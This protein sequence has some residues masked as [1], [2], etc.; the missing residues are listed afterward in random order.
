MNFLKFFYILVEWKSCSRA[1]GKFFKIIMKIPKWMAKKTFY[2]P[3]LLVIVVAF[4]AHQA[5]E[6]S[7]NLPENDVNETM[8]KIIKS[9]LSDVVEIPVEVSGTILPKEYTR[10]QSKVGAQVRYMAPVGSSVTRG[11]PVVEFYDD[12]I[13]QTYFQSLVAVN[14]AQQNL[15]EVLGLT[16]E[17]IRQAELAVDSAMASLKSA[18]SS[19][20][21]VQ[22]QNSQNLSA[23]LDSAEVA[24]ESAYNTID[25]VLRYWGKGGSLNEFIL[26]DTPNSN[27]SLLNDTTNKFESLKDEYM[28]LSPNISGD[29]KLALVSI[30][31]VLNDTRDFN[32]SVFK[33][34]NYSVAIPALDYPQS[35]IDTYKLKSIALSSQINADNTRVKT[36]K[37]SVES[38]DIASQGAYIS[39]KNQYDQAQIMYDN[40]LIALDSTRRQSDIRILGAQ[41]Q[42][43]SAQLQ[44]TRA[45]E[46]YDNLYLRAPFDGVIIS[47]Q[48]NVGDQVSPGYQIIEMGKTDSVE[49]KLSID[50][51]GAKSLFIGKEVLINDKYV[52]SISEISPTASLTTGKMTFTVSA[53]NTE[54]SLTPGSV[55][56]V[57]ITTFVPLN[58]PAVVLNL[59]IVT[60]NQNEA[61]V[62]IAKPSN[63]EWYE[64]EKREVSLGE[65][66]NNKVIVT[67]GIDEG[68]LII[69]RSGAFISEG[70]RVMTLKE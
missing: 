60:V 6:P 22:L 7:E 65:T 35:L 57:S 18:K 41:S 47:Q 56:R 66:Y 33:V 38:V 26:R 61:F 44:L 16:A 64:V 2:L 67:Q 8:V 24:Y 45:R 39:A 11:E 21:N 36:S 4:V 19:F 25:Q 68:D 10:I 14:V 54:G 51:Y 20:E 9:T 58:P 53:S 49:I 32:N 5:T 37:S 1:Y 63:S 34:L 27:L 29:V 3:V 40:S 55:G 43:T 31:R 42:L 15:D 52:G 46:R 59:D 30:E 48:V 17:S 70:D 12:A 28:L 23:I 13:S 50:E 62:F 69:D